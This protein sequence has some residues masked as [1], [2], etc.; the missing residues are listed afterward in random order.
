MVKTCFQTSSLALLLSSFFGS[1]D[2]G[3]I[4]TKPEI[5]IFS[6][7]LYRDT[8]DPKGIGI[9]RAFTLDLDL[10]HTENKKHRQT[11]DLLWIC[12]NITKLRHT[13]R[14]FFLGTARFTSFSVY[15]NVCPITGE[16]NLL[17]LGFYC[18][19]HTFAKKKQ[20]RLTVDW[21]ALLY[22]RRRNSNHLFSVEFDLM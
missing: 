6:N 11:S 20:S 15:T 22:R 13:C 3:C 5:Y 12:T 17:V 7:Y 16:S 18:Y 19:V 8:I 21:M 10:I 14:G 9:R 4:V 1:L 2:C